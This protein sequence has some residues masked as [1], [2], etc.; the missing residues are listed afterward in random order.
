[1]IERERAIEH[2]FMLYRML[3]NDRCPSKPQ[4]ARHL[5]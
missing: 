3:G 5:P 2:D 1:M 4:G